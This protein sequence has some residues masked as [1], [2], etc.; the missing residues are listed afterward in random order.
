[1][2]IFRGRSRDCAYAVIVLLIAAASVQ[3]Q[4]PPPAPL[5]AVLPHVL[6]DPSVKMCM[7]QT[8][9]LPSCQEQCMIEVRTECPIAFIYAH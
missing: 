5:G 7:S 6:L 3:A 1:M 9:T 8:N 4:S 2:T